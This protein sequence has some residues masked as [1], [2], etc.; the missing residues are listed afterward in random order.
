MPLGSIFVNQKA[1]Q[2]TAPLVKEVPKP[3]KGNYEQRKV[4]FVILFSYLGFAGGCL[5]V[6]AVYKALKPMLKE[7]LYK[8]QI[9]QARP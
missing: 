5:I 9:I 7:K 3:T 4:S 2:E 1:E 6:W 8:P